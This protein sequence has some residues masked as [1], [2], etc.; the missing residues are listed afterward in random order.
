ME[1][2]RFLPLTDYHEY[3]EVEMKGRVS[4]FYT[5]VM[6]RRTV[7][8]FS[9][10]P[11]DR[12]VIETCLRAASTAPSGANQQPWTFVVVSDPVVKKRIRV[13][14]EKVEQ[15]F[16]D[17]EASRKWVKALEHLGTVPNKPFLETAPYLIAV[18]FQFYGYS[19]SGEKR[20]GV[21]ETK[22]TM[23]ISAKRMCLHSSVTIALLAL[24][25]LA[26]CKSPQKDYSIQKG[27]G[28]GTG[29]VDPGFNTKERLGKLL[30]FEK[31]LSTPPGQDCSACHAPEIAFADPESDLP[32]SKGARPGLYG[33]RNDMTVSYAAFVP[34]LHL[35]KDEGI[36]VGG[37]FWDG[38]VDS[39]AEQA[40]G[41]PLN[42]LEM[43][44][45]DML[46]IAEKLRG[47]SY[48]ELFTEAYGP[49]A[50]SNPATAFNNMANAIEAY[51]KTSEVS[52]F[53]SKYDHWL[54]GE[55]ELGK[56]ELRGLE[57]FEAEDK[58]NC[59]AC[60]PSKP[61]KDG[62]PPLFTDFTY[63]N[64]GTPRNPENPFYS[65]PP[66]L[67]PDGFAFVDLG[68]GKTVDDRAQNGKF[69]VP[70]LRNAAVTP[71]YMHNGVFKTLFQV[72]AFYNTRDVA[73]W[74][75]PEVCE[76]IN[77]EEL[78]DLGLTNEELED[79]VAFL[80]TLTDGWKRLDSNQQ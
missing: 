20:V 34:P 46:T 19:A 43:A 37:L 35:D 56:Q 51:E 21:T 67:N 41:P 38:R 47:L 18:F 12:S 62:S 15:E 28:T 39:L 36:W 7:R 24:C 30:F 32:V 74:P 68:L 72:M 71:P 55:T 42:P 27:S 13:A 69:R 59:A 45:P 17:K 22:G 40:Q 57:L 76:N 70:T 8:H 75:A 10:R 6:R 66:E 78:G 4:E 48:A 5:E 14:A 80:R 25:I 60:H 1:E 26:G 54:R 11:V 63:D 79:L 23:M 33:N 50:L 9:G 31:S 77:M 2:K 65:L 61:V 58:G 29:S 73:E 49:D 53:S 64:L 16:Y 44:N 3:P 52:P